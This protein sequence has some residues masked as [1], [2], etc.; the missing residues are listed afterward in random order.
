MRNLRRQRGITLIS[1]IIVLTVV[2][3]FAYVGMKLFPMYSE[4]YG[5]VRALKVVQA[6]PGVAQMTPDR[7]WQVLSNNL[8]TNYVESVKRT[9]VTITRK[10]GYIL[11]V[12]YEVRAPLIFNLDVVAKFDTSVDL[13]RSDPGGG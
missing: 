12:A 9:N 3:I 4:Y 13:V 11:R 7:I 8:Y 10:G 2:G 6:T 5:V 1:L